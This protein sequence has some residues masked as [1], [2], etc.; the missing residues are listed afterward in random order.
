[1]KSAAVPSAAALLALAAA[2]ALAADPVAVSLGGYMNAGVAYVD[3]GATDPDV[4]V[5]RDGEIHFDARGASDNGLTFR[6]R[7]ELE[8]FTTDDQIDESWVSVSGGFGTILVGQADTA[9]NEQGGVGVVKPSGSYFNYYDYDGGADLPGEP[10]GFVGEDD[11]IGLR[12]FVEFRGFE[13]GASWQPDADA[14]GANDTNNPSLSG[15][16]KADQYAF[17]A[18][19]SGDVGDVGLALGGG[20]L[21]NDLE[22]VWH[23][24]A[25]AGYAGFTLAGFYNREEEDGAPDVERWSAGA[26]YET[27]PTTLG[28]GFVLQD[29]GAGDETFVHLG[30]GYALAPGVTAYG[31][32]Q[33]GEDGGGT[34]GVAALAWLGLDF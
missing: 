23:V 8:A 18:S 3:D 32:V 25:E 19:W 24:G 13:A 2:P 9:L 17:G 30:A 1:M 15:G 14:D 7:V 16:P 4:G 21:V 12:Y 26:Q 28:G 22:D 33:Y 5:M 27:G 20:Y 31:A 10:G 11:A 6:G 34:E 29:R